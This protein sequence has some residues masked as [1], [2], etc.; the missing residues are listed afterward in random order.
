MRHRRHETLSFSLRVLE[1][2]YVRTT[3]ANKAWNKQ[4]D[5][6]LGIGVSYRLSKR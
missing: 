1:L 5:L 6:R 3:L 2:G 4:N